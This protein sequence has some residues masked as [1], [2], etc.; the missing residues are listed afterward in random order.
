MA[1]NTSILRRTSDRN[2]FLAAAIA[3]PLLVFVGYFKTYYFSAF[4]DVKPIA[5]AL[6]HA[7]GIVM[8]LWV[9][10]FT[11]QVVL[12][13]SK[14]IKLHMTLGIAGI[15]L[16]AL[17]I[18]IGFATAW[19]SHIVRATAPGGVH[20]HSFFIVPVVNMA[21]FIV[22]FAGAIYFRKRPAEHKTLMLL[23]ALNFLP[24]AIGR[25]PVPIPPKLAIFWTYGV[26][27]LI[28]ITCLIWYTIKYRKLNKIFALG[29]LLLLISQP[30]RVYFAFTETWLLFVGWIAS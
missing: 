18:I 28:A 21:L 14:N 11:V 3:Y 23:T 7:H 25:I 12:I 19:D 22:F 15:L 8:S 9:V 2:L 27:D 30:L 20:P 29:V 16:A 1:S 17:V 24:A 5:N 6:V 4:F 13:R 10:Y 26:S